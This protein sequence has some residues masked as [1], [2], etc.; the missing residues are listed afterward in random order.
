MFRKLSVMLFPFFVCV[1]FADQVTL[2][3]GDRATG[4]IL[5]KDG[6]SLTFKSDAFGNITIPWEKVDRLA[7]D[8]QLTV[9]L[10]SGKS[11][12]GKLDTKDNKLEV[13][14]PTIKE[15]IPIAEVS[16]IRN[17]DEQRT[18]DKLEHPGLLNLWSGY[19][20][21]G[22]SLARGNAHTTTMTTAL[23]ASRETKGDKTSAYF[24]QIYATGKDADG[25]RADTAQAVRGGWAYNKNVSPRL[26]VNLLNDYE[27]DRFQDLDLR[28]VIG[29]GLGYILIKNERTRLD[30]LGGADY[31]RERFSTPLIRNSAELLWGDSL[32]H[33][34]SKITAL[35]QAFRMFHNLSELGAYRMNFDLGTVTNLNKWLAWQLT[36]SDRYL[37]NPVGGS[38]KNDVMFTTGIRVSF[39]KD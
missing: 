32:S 2:K 12:L 16:A 24:N 33:K 26:F 3:N 38:R 35:T 8:D 14:T 7:S 20:D 25:L 30:F 11:V 27:R 6:A 19:A 17:T 31:N 34:I 13:T 28:F 21:L 9:V 29:G 18:K 15:S 5:K 37:S 36:L 10:P 22:V 1:A 23:N 4:K 39:A